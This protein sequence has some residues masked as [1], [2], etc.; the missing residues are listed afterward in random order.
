MA[1]AETG[2]TWF[3]FSLLDIRVSLFRRNGIFIMFD[4]PLFGIAVQWDYPLYDKLG[5]GR[6]INIGLLQNLVLE[7]A[8]YIYRWRWEKYRFTSFELVEKGE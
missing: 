7:E 3:R 1:I 5:V 6:R 2:R 4:T 8:G